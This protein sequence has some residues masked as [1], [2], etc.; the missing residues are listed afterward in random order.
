MKLCSIA[1]IA[2]LVSSNALAGTATGKILTITVSNN[3]TVVLFSL[4]SPIDKTPK[5]N[6]E[7][8]FS[9]ELKKPGGMA[10]YKAIL[11][12]KKQ[13]YQ[14]TVNGLNTCGWKSENVKD[15]TLY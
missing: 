10:F 8:R 1:V 4:T 9:V 15:I 5:C 13:D 2:I 7:G 12:A 14:V 3:T 6:E 11:E